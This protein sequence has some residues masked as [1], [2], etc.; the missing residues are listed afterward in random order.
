M[1]AQ[2]KPA[3]G[4]KGAGA[5]PKQ[6][7]RGQWVARLDLGIVNGKRVRKAFYGKSRKE[8]QVKLDKARDELRRG[9]P[10]AN[11]RKTVRA[12]LADEWLPSVKPHVR[13]STYRSYE[14][15]VRLY[16]APGLGHHRLAALQ[17]EHV[18]A[19]MAAK[20]ADGLAPLSVR[21]FLVILRLALRAAMARGLL[22]RNVATLVKPPRVEHRELTI[23]D[24]DQAGRFLE[25]ARGDRLEALYSVALTLGLRQGEAL[26]LRWSDVD[27]GARTLTVR[28][29]MQ[30]VGKVP[31]GGGLRHVETK[32]AT[33]R[34]TLALPAVLVLALKAHR[35]RQEDEKLLACGRWQDRGLVFCTKYGTPLDGPNVTKYFQKLLDRAGL[36]R[37]RYHDLRHSCAS[38]LA[39]MGV[40]ITVAMDIL[41]HSD[42][43]LTANVYTHVLGDSKR[44]AAAAMDRLFAKP[45]EHLTP[46]LPLTRQTA[47]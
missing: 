23:L 30:R 40:P 17:P 14:Q 8:A 13:A 21:R 35:A 33:S 26:G 32:S 24:P 6:N 42:V 11:D 47:S 2:G 45:Q 22:A 43:R 31:A 29:A 25:A 19:L 10:V 27:L 3:R 37:M 28:A 46:T 1:G 12:F 39:A 9:L 18:E 38:F 36:P 7:G 44:E 5:A 34:R 41:G 20:T 16:L 4:V 15:N